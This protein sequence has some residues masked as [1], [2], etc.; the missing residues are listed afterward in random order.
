VRPLALGPEATPSSPGSQ[1]RRES[2]T[3]GGPEAGHVELSSGSM[4]LSKHIR[5]AF[6]EADLKR[7]KE[8]DR[9]RNEYVSTPSS[10]SFPLTLPPD[11]ELR[12]ALAQLNTVSNSTTSRLDDTYYSILEQTSTLQSTVTA[13]QDLASL[14]TQLYRDF[15]DEAIDLESEVKAQIGDLSGFETQQTRVAELEAR[16]K[17]GKEK[18]DEFIERVGFVRGRIEGWERREGEWQALMSRECGPACHR[19]CIDYITNIIQAGFECS[20]PSC[21]SV[22]LSSSRS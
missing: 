10:H 12:N 1:S 7:E 3:V 6:T 22:S 16:I 2:F 13:L 21:S 11:R 8:L 14:T 4:A 15:E 5:P 20:S 17:E 9:K 18:I 19:Q